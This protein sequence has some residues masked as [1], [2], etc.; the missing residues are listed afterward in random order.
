[1][2]LLLSI[3]LALM[4]GAAAISFTSTVAEAQRYRVVCVAPDNPACR[5]ACGSNQHAVM[6]F[7]QMR[8]GRCFR[9]CGPPR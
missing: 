9:Y 7:A 8:N 6:C 5:T 2:R 1:M 3:G 4:L